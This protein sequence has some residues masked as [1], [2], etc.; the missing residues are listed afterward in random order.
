MAQSRARICAVGTAEDMSRLLRV[1]L[2][3]CGY[4]PEELEP[5]P[6]SLSDLTEA[7]RRVIREESGPE[8]EFLYE[9]ISPVRFGDA[10]AG[11]CR[12][13]LKEERCGFWT[14]LFSYES[15][16]PFQAHEWLD[17]HR[18]A[19][20]LPLTAFHACDEFQLEKGEMLFVGGEASERWDDMG[21]IWWWL[22]HRDI[23][24]QPPEDARRA[25]RKLNSELED[26]M[27]DMDAEELV[28]SAGS[29]M[30]R[31][32]SAMQ[33]P[34]ALRQDLQDA[35]QNRRWDRLFADQ[36]LL[37]SAVMMIRKPVNLYCKDRLFGN[38]IVQQ[39]INM[40]T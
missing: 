11:S 33:D 17:L 23:C 20:K 32:N 40:G 19:G 14:A 16:H 26:A 2:T 15:A 7:L 35:V 24:A 6:H 13:Q 37:F 12:F 3:N 31:L 5:P 9:M 39:E 8:D 30:A 22:W 34:D 10:L 1:M 36:L 21:E 29:I 18:R 4:P 38:F 25:L 27:Y 28:R